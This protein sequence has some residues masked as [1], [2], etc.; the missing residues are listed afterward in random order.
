MKAL[1]YQMPFIVT[2]AFAMTFNSVASEGIPA[3]PYFATLSKATAAEL[4]SKSAELVSNADSKQ[5]RQTTIDVVGAAVPLNPAAAPAIVGS[6]SQSSPDMASVAAATAVSLVPD[7]ATV[8]AH[9]AAAAAPTKAGQI[10]EAICRVLPGDYQKIA[11]AVAEVVPGAG[12][13]ILTAIS[14]AIPALKDP[15]N[16]VL[17]SD[18]GNMPPVSS[19]LEQVKSNAPLVAD[20][21]VTPSTFNTPSLAPPTAGPPFVPL[22]PQHQNIDPGSGGQVPPGGRNYASP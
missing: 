4:P 13:E 17:A 1:K 22:P 7:Q 8:I 14:A 15:I 5:Q 16:Q 20:A 10:V 12:K 19:V 21:P 18:K 11:E 9:V 2:V 3:N 6:I